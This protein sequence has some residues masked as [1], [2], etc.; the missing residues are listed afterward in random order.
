MRYIT[1]NID[2]VPHAAVMVGDDRVLV[3]DRA[4]GEQ[5]STVRAIIEGGQA[6]WDK[7][8]ELHAAPP[9]HCLVERD[10]VKLAASLPNPIR[11]RDCTLFTEHIEPALRAV[12]R[13]RAQEAEDPEAEYQRM[14][15]E[16]KCEL[17]DVLR[18]QF[19][20]YNGD[21]LSI[22]GPDE[23]ITAPTTSTVLDYELEFAAVLGTG[24]SDISEAD[25]GRHIF[26][27]M[28]FNDWSARDVQ[29]EVMKSSLGPAEGKDF[30]GSN[31]FG[32]YLVTA[33]EIENPYGLEMVARVNGQEWSRGSSAS[34]TYSFEFAV[35][36]LSRGKRLYA[37]DVLGSGTVLSGSAFEQ[38]RELRAGDVVEL[39][40]D[41]LGTLTNTV[42]YA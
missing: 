13:R 4:L 39:Q 24:G 18:R 7:V 15:A 27:Y 2:S 34:M 11:L 16:G 36:H 12:A 3:L 37:G 19:V 8:A 10:A 1:A 40:I 31:T 41:Q 35:A 30:D 38:N 29:S 5:F 6:A 23:I 32:P 9:E 20:Y 33:D 17:P 21:H 26:G 14:V 25:A 28:I 22:S 42:A